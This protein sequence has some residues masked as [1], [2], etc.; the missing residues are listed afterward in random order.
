MGLAKGGLYRLGFF[1]SE[2]KMA[3]K[4][5]VI[6]KQCFRAKKRPDDPQMA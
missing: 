3:G 6:G 5:G 2:G 1:A 4:P